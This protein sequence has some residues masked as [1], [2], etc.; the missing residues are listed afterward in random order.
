MSQPVVYRDFSQAELDA[1][2]NNRVRFPD[3]HA[4]F[5]NWRRWSDETKARLPCR[6]DLAF[7]QSAVETLDVFPAE[8]G[9]AAPVYLFIH[10]GYWYSLDKADYG[11]VAVG[12]RPHGVATVINNYG[13]APDHDMDEIVRQNRA[14]LAWVYRHATDFGGDPDRIFVA[15]HSAGG[16]LAAMLVATDWPALEAGLPGDLVKGICAIGGLFDL[17][18]IR[19]SYL[20]ETLRLDP[21]SAWRNSPIHQ[22]YSRPTPAL[23]VVGHD[24]SPEFH[25]QTAIMAALWKR[26]DLPGESLTAQAFDHFSVANDLM[27][28]NG[29]LVPRQLKLFPA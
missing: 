5:A 25:R 26:L 21:A 15:G 9:A 14:A 17:E 12:M 8:P 13:L 23:L 28:P 19:L 6:L 29:F 1:Q 2:Y 3:F 18:P 24:E 27:D 4:H 7:G 22:T 10:G 11:F 16:H 20:N